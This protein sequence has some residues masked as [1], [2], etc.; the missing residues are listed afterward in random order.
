MILD[1]GLSFECRT[2]CDPRLLSVEDIYTIA[3]ELK[4]KGIKE[5]YLQK[6]RQVEGDDTP[7][8][9]CDKFFEDEKLLSYLKSSFEVFD[10]RK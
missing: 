7:D 5:Y 8:S 10:V 3:D 6:Y 4:A 1:S 9:E 2:T